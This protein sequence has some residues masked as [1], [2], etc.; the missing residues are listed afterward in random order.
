MSDIKLTAIKKAIGLL[1]AAGAQYKVL[2]DDVV[3][4]DT[5]PAK[6]G[7]KPYK[8]SG[9][10]YISHF[11]QEVEKLEN[12]ETS[13]LTIHVPEHLDVRAFRGAL[14]GYLSKRFG[15]GTCITS[16]DPVKRTV[17]VLYAR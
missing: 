14:A 13:V 2:L 1:A 3:V 9:A 17:E 12:P 7:K 16:I 6:P 11:K 15:N 5:I 10:E 4:I 8:R